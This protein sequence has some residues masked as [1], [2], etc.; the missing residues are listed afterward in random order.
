ME[1]WEDELQARITDI[2]AEF[3]DRGITIRQVIGVLETT[4]GELLPHLM[5]IEDENE[6]P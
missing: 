4:K 2:I 5:I 6:Q 3:V 1:E